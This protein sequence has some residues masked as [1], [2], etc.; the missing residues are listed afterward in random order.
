M[1]AIKQLEPSGSNGAIQI[2][3]DGEL[4][5]SPKLFFD[6]TNSRLGIGTLT[7]EE[8]LHVVGDVKIDGT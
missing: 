6:I 7:P 4:D 1:G 5:W 2:Q 8:L 3:R